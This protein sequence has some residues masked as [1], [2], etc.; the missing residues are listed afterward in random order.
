MNQKELEEE[1]TLTW[2]KFLVVKSEGRDE[3][4]V[5]LCDLLPGSFC[6]DCGS[7]IIKQMKNSWT[8]DEELHSDEELFLDEELFIRGRALS[9]HINRIGRVA[10]GVVGMKPAISD[11]P[12]WCLLSLIA[13]SFQNS[14]WQYLVSRTQSGKQKAF[15]SGT[16]LLI[17]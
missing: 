15:P 9:S 17:G 5:P 12:L 16:T 1:K 3:E 13:R 4:P 10:R 8:L 7:S 11:T 14:L 2:V 6:L